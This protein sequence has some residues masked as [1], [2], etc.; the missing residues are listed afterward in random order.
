MLKANVCF[1]LYY[2]KNK[3]IDFRQSRYTLPFMKQNQ[4]S[5]PPDAADVISGIFTARRDL[6]YGDNWAVKGSG[7]TVEE[8]DL[9]VSLYGAQVLNWDDLA[10]DKGGFVAFSELERFLVHSASL[11]SR[12]IRKLADTK[13]P[14]VE[15][16]GAD[17]ASG[18]HFNAKRVRITKEG[19][20]RIEPVWQRYEQVAVRLLE[21][22]PA[23]DLKAHLAVNEAISTEMKKWRAG[24]SD[25]FRG[26]L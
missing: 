25:R 2:V 26:M 24:V 12:R 9:L 14:L 19:V 8:A 3:N 15:V 21:G 22:I 23:S 4:P 5:G 6:V 17:L 1:I 20:K 16:A 13:P 7:F 18:Q 11:L 10:H